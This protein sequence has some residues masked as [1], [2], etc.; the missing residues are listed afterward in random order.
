MESFVA[1]DYYDPDCPEIEIKLDSRLSPAQNGQKMYKLYNKAKNAKA[2]LTEQIKLWERELEYLDGVQAFLERAEGEDDL[3]EIRDELYRVGYASRM[4]GYRPEKKPKIKYTEF[5]SP[6]GYRVRVGRNNTQ[7]DELSHKLAEK[8]DIWFHVKDIPGSHVIM[9]TRGEE[10]EAEDYTFAA[11][12]AAY[13]S[14]A[15]RGEL[16]PVDYTAVKNLKKPQGSKPGFV[17]YKT[18]YTAYVKPSL[19]KE[20]ES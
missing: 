1:T 5:I 18:N 8:S 20:G 13:Y 2:T 14:K 16:V 3:S 10:P 11:S 4:K 17:T 15:A 6:S 12:L 19:P 7:N 9:E